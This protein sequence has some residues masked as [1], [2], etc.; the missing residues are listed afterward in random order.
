MVPPAMG[1]PPRHGADT[2]R[3]DTRVRRP[4]VTAALASSKVP[5]VVAAALRT[6]LNGVWLGVLTDAELAALD[7]SYYE[8]ATMYRTASWNERGLFD[9]EQR[10]VLDHFPPGARIIV[11]ACGGG[12]EVLALLKMGFD[13]FGYES[14][15]ALAAFAGD[16]MAEHG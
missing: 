1:T 9:W 6:L 5:V 12:R 4:L 2:T 16:F 8:Q 10:L 3:P 15:P 11:T 7:E 13:V 14:H